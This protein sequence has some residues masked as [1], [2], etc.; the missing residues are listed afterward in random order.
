MSTI[1]YQFCMTTLRTGH[2][3]SYK[4]HFRPLRTASFGT[5]SRFRCVPVR[6]RLQNPLCIVHPVGAW[7]MLLRCKVHEEKGVS[8][9]W[10]FVHYIVVCF[11]DLF[12]GRTPESSVVSKSSSFKLPVFQIAQQLMF[13]LMLFGIPSFPE[14]T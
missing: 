11:Q 8:V 14:A 10:V 1:N 7:M 5:G 4:H 12:F 2:K 6:S 9:V 13:P 3:V